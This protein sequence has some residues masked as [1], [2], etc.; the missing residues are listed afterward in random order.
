MFLFRK[1]K[2][3]I[4]VWEFRN[5]WNFWNCKNIDKHISTQLK[6]KTMNPPDPAPFVLGYQYHVCRRCSTNDTSR[7]L[8]CDPRS[9]HLACG[10]VS[11]S[12]NSWIRWSQHRWKEECLPNFTHNWGFQ[13]SMVDGRCAKQFRTTWYIRWMQSSA[14]PSVRSRSGTVGGHTLPSV[15]TSL[16][17]TPG[18]KMLNCHSLGQSSPAFNGLDICLV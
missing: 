7:H 8:D 18:W 17:T 4:D 11:L 6:T 1:V 14:G 15:T 5:E 13:S 16:W 2:P 3:Q 12:L 10:F 9:I